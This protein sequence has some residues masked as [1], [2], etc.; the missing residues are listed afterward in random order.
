MTNILTFDDL[1]AEVE[2]TYKAIPFQGPTGEVFNLRALV[3]LPRH[4]R[5][6]IL[7]AVKIVND[8]E[9]DADSQEDAID[10]VLLA[11][12]D[13]ANGFSAVLDALPLAAKAK[14]IKAWSEATQAPEA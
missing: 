10:A 9:S 5:K 4:E 3:L 8:G 2:E 11:V 13:N 14:L 12:A 6:A 1:M 7:D